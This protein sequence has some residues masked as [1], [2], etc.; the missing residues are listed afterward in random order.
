MGTA[1]ACRPIRVKEIYENGY[2]AE[3]PMP[4]MR[5]RMAHFVG[6]RMV[7]TD[8]ANAAKEMIIRAYPKRSS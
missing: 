4:G 3:Y 2:T 6:S 7:V 1:V 5:A 8:S